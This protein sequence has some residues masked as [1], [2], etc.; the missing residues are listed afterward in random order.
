MVKKVVQGS[1]KYG[2]PEYA[3]YLLVKE[4]YHCTPSELDEQDSF[5]TDLHIEFMGLEAKEQKLQEKRAEQS[6]KFK[7]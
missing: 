3:D 1:S 6:Q 7:K 2:P 4:L 5:I